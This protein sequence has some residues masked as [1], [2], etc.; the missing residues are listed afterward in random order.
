MPGRR[1]DGHG[2]T[3][4]GHVPGRIRGRIR[5]RAWTLSLSLTRARGRTRPRGGGIRSRVQA[6]PRV[7]PRSAF[8]LPIPL[9]EALEIDLPHLAPIDLERVEARRPG[10]AIEAQ[11][12][13]RTERARLD[14]AQDVLV[15][16]AGP[17][18]RC[19]KDAELHRDLVRPERMEERA[20]EYREGRRH[21]R[22]GRRGGDAAPH[23]ARPVRSRRLRTSRRIPAA[24]AA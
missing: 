14:G 13:L 23:A 24:R 4:A 12:E 2:R 16:D 21:Q 5:I 18:A 3:A 9:R 1:A 19:R 11:P 15:D 8:L 7:F 6:R 10:R 22:Q 17:R 20:R